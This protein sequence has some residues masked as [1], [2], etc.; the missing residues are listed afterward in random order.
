MAKSLKCNHFF[1]QAASLKTQPGYIIIGD[2]GYLL[3]KV[4]QS[5]KSIIR[6]SMPTFELLTLYGDELKF[7]ELS[8]YLDSYSIFSDNR[9]LIIRNCERLGE[10]DKNRKQPELHKRMAELI[11]NYL[12]DPDSS[13]V[14]VLIADSV[15]NRLASWK[16]LKELCLTIE[17]E[18]I[19][20]PGEMR[21]WLETILRNHKKT[22]DNR[23]KDLFLNKVE[24]DFCT[25]ENEIKKLFV[26]VGDRSHIDEKDVTTTLPTTRAGTL[27][28][29]YKALGNRNTKEIINKV[30]DM[31]D[32]DW[33]DL[34]ILS[35][36][37]RFFLT[38]WKIQALQNKHYT[39]KEILTSHLNDFFPSQREAY[40]AYA[41]KYKPEELP[42]VFEII[43]ETDS[44]IK[45]SMAES[46][47]LLALSIVKICN[48][49]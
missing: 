43:L 41:A 34:Q 2:D 25:A 32:N 45:L 14:I 26:F 35:N 27:T 11:A 16:K 6:K 7:S 24:L 1:E 9:L 44:Q 21:A 39:N 48:D 18:P 36:I 46:R 10:E 47:V 42:T 13:Q 23:A 28:D 22:M 33:A 30:N 20:Y 37:S 4:Y 17:C 8:E 12:T 29:F 15:D 40:L 5:I 31:L 38:V 3:D 19:K 49:K